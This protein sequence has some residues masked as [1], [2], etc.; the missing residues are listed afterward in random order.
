MLFLFPLCLFFTS[1]LSIDCQKPS[2]ERPIIGLYSRT[3]MY[4][5]DKSLSVT[6]HLVYTFFNV[7]LLPIIKL[8]FRIYFH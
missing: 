5:T 8:K 7:F 3:V 4:I 6:Y 1:L 2:N